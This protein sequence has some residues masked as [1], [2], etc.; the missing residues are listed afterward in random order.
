MKILDPDFDKFLTTKGV[1]DIEKKIMLGFLLNQQASAIGRVNGLQSAA[2]DLNRQQAEAQ[3][4]ADRV[5]A[6]LDKFT[7]EVVEE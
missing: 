2:A 5:T 7:D 1:T 6:M 4:E 3:A